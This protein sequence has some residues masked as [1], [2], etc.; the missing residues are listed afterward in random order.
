MVDPA[1]FP[2]VREKCQSYEEYLSLTEQSIEQELR[3]TLISRTIT[4][5]QGHPIGTIQLYDIANKTGFLATWIGAP[6]FGQGY[7]RR[8]KESFFTELFLGHGIETVFLKIRKHN[9]RSIK[10]IEK[11]PYVELANEHNPRIYRSINSMQPIYDLYRV[12]RA[13]FLES[14]NLTIHYRMTRGWYG[15]RLQRQDGLWI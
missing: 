13:R 11:L 12:E 8:A 9:I 1:V 4:N 2:Y 5:D 3:E 7:N 14:R 15:C 10:A 6:Y